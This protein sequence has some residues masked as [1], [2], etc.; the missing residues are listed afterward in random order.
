MSGSMVLL[1]C[2]LSLPHHGVAL[3]LDRQTK[4]WMMHYV[5]RL[6]FAFCDL[7]T[8][9]LPILWSDHR[10]LLFFKL[11]LYLLHYLNNVHT[12]LVKL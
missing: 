11:C 5:F 1:R 4:F 9:A 12:W 10:A 8:S 2:E 6:T 7:S 3:W